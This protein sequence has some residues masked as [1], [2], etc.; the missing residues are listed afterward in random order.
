MEPDGAVTT[1]NGWA[2]AARGTGGASV[3]ERA[4][5]VWAAVIIALG[6]SVYLSAIQAGFTYDDV[7]TIL[8]H[9]GVRGPF[10]AELLFFRDFW[11]RSFDQTV[12][13][14]RPVATLSFWLDWHIAGGKAWPFHLTNL[15]S[16][17]ALLLV[18]YVFLKRWAGNALSVHARLM[19]L[20]AFA[21][22]VIHVD[23]VPGA[24]GRTEIF[25]ATFTLAAMR[26][27]M[28]RGSLLCAWRIVASAAL[29]ALA[30]LSKESAYPMALALPWIVGRHHQRHGAMSHGRLGALAAGHLLVLVGMIAFRLGKLPFAITTPATLPDNPL[31]A[32]PW[33][34]QKLGAAEVSTHYVE[35]TLTGLDLVPD[36]SYFA[37]PVLHGGPGLRAVLGV[38]LVVGLLAAAL[39]LRRRRPLATDALVGFAGSYLVASHF[40][41]P[42]SAM[43]ADRLFFF[44]SFWLVVFGAVML[45]WLPRLQANA[46]E[47]PRRIG[48]R[49]MAA[50]AAIAWTAVQGVIAAAAATIW[51]DNAV[52]YTQA[53][54]TYPH[55]SRTRVNFSQVLWIV[56]RRDEAAWHLLLSRAYYVRFP[57][58]IHHDDFPLSWDDLPI[59]ER[60]QALRAQLGD[61]LTLKVFDRTLEFCDRWR[62][63][64][65][66]EILRRWREPIAADVGTR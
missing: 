6:V 20:A 22:L 63:Q 34:A 61:P 30:M 11:G 46:S 36:Y 17:G 47:Q 29:L 32:M 37:V 19:A 21:M 23:V 65:R 33:W 48:L 1:W 13:T 24:T 59:P 9:A 8:S 39:L 54:Q 18:A 31:L 16:Y 66:S 14:W 53:I 57:G 45:D 64:G 27:A 51:R 62:L 3:S 15:L 44:P 56:G 42:A 28:P 7:Q 49:R 35:H 2:L 25:A 60:L 50:A 58:P 12:G 41:V 55:V 40:V 5:R 4:E 10:S 52:L 26:V 43:L 38:L